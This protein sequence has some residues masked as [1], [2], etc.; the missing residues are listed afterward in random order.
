MYRILTEQRKA[1]NRLG[2]VIRP[3]KQK[4]K[5]LDVYKNGFKVA[6]IGDTRYKDYW[7]YKKEERQGKIPR[8]TADQRRELYRIRHAENCMSKNSPGYYACEILW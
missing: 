8:G 2:V 1:A 5:K 4:F 6:S 7:I 3:S